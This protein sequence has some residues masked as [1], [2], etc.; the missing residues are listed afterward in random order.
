MGRNPTS[1]GT[2]ELLTP[3][4]LLRSPRKMLTILPKWAKYPHIQRAHLIFTTIFSSHSRR[5]FMSDLFQAWNS[6]LNITYIERTASRFPN[7]TWHSKYVASA[8]GST[9]EERREVTAPGLRWVRSRTGFCP[10]S[11]LQPVLEASWSKA[12][13]QTFSSA[14]SLSLP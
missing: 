12:S 9:Q 3:H 2:P 13:L 7:S 6:Y 11:V 10:Y 1:L 14:L 4:I 8:H 5:F